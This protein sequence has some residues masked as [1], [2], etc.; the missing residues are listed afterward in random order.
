MKK[1]PIYSFNKE[2]IKNSYLR[3]AIIVSLWNKLITNRLYKSVY[4]TLIQFGIKKN[5]INTWEVPGSLELI[6]SSKEIACRYN[7]DSIIAIGSI[8]K[9]ETYHF[10]YLCKTVL[11]GIKDINLIHNVPVISCILTDKNK[12]QSI[13]R[14]GGKNG[15][16]GVECA[17]TAIYMSLFKKSIN[18]YYTNITK[19][20]N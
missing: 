6:F 15:N 18:E 11:Q 17:K 19:R 14:S 16:K 7:F 13:D 3:I 1:S 2:K 8:I 9:G 12:Q 10:E 20:S 5:K 4:K